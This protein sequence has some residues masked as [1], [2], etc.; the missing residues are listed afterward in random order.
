M[1]LERAA[2]SPGLIAADP[3]VSAW[4]GASAG[5]GK[6]NL[7]ADRVLR[8]L[9][10][11]A[12][13]SA[14]LCLTFTKAAA[15]EMAKRIF[16]RLGRWAVADDKELSQSLRELLGEAPL[17]PEDL[18][19]ARQLFA[20][21][22]DAPGG[23]RIQ[24][25]HAF[26]ESLLK[27]F[28]LE[29]NV[30]PQFAI[31]DERTQAD[32]VLEAQN[33]LFAEA[34]KA[35][36]GALGRAL[37]HLAS[38]T[39]EQ[40]LYE[41]FGEIVKDRKKFS[42]LLDDAKG[43][44]GL[45]VKLRRALGLGRDETEQTALGAFIAEI[46]R[47]KA[48]RAAE[49][50]GHGAKTDLRH[51]ALI[52][53]WLQRPDAAGAYPDTLN[54]LFLTDEGEA[55]KTLVT[56][57]I[58][59]KFPDMADWLKE[60]QARA[61][62]LQDKLKTIRTFAAT[63]AMLRLADFLLAL[64]EDKKRARTLL[65][66]EDLIHTARDLVQTR[67]L[68][69]WVL[70]KLDQGIDH[71]L[72]D[73]AQDTSPAQ[74][75][76]IAA[77]AEEFFAGLGAREIERT[78]FAVGD[79]KQSIFSF[80]GAEPEAFAEMREHFRAKVED[81]ARAFRSVPLARNYRSVPAILAAV[82]RVFALAQ[83]KEG[84]V[85]DGP[86]RHFA[87]REGQG[88]F[89][90]LW[91]LTEPL[92]EQPADPWDAPL[93]YVGPGR[94]EARLARRI[95]ETLK[96]WIGNEVLAAQGRPVKAGDIMILVR[97]RG[98]FFEH[99]VRELKKAGV[100]VAGA[101]R[102]VLA[103]HLAVMDL[104]A[105]GAFA[106][107]PSD[108]L[109]LAI[110]LKSP[111]FGFDDDDLLK[112]CAGRR[113]SLWHALLARQTEHAHWQAAADELGRLLAEADFKPP[114]EFYA[115]LLGARQGRARILARLGPDAADPMDEFLNAA[116]TY[117]SSHAA[118]LQGFLH[119]FALGQSVIKRDLEQAGDQVRVMTVHGAKGLEANIVFL[120]ETTTKPDGRHDPAFFWSEGEGAALPMRNLGQASDV[121]QAGAA[122]ASWRAA[123]EREYRRLLY[124]AMTRAR[125][126]L[127]VCGWRPKRYQ[128]EGTWYGLIKTALEGPDVREVRLAN[129]E[130]GS[131]LE[132]SQ[133]QEPEAREPVRESPARPIPALFGTLPDKEPTP[134]RPLSPS[135]PL[136]LEPPPASPLA[137]PRA[138]A[139]ERGALVHR[140]LEV[141]P[142]I[143]PHRRED[144]ARALIARLAP[145]L[146]VGARTE[147][148]ASALGVLRDPDC[149]GVFA[150]E[151]R[152]EVPILG[153]IGDF[154]ISGRIDR[155]AV[156]GEEVAILDYK[157]NRTPPADQSGVSPVYLRQMAAYR[158]IISR[159]YPAH[160]VRAALLWTSAPKLM[161]LD[162][163]RLD[164]ALRA[165]TETP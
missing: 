138:I 61:L 126:R 42:G 77:L 152:S 133:E 162:D 31:A 69:P 36:D 12:R 60:A 26:C 149:A 46:D 51:S 91:P 101:D 105:V 44:A 29:A 95:A 17:A 88:G 59:K 84:V 3:S 21:T 113:G 41:A 38:T 40:T 47:V 117:Q 153:R 142:K 16:E 121:A 70:Y 33:A 11:G 71:I 163:E 8:L 57:A 80:Q 137:E 128:E 67:E 98:P 27:R 99:M 131:R 55:R 74:W 22:L 93:D 125:D 89:V 54:K 136:D 20:R 6:T 49:I 83:A 87:E 124:V 102:L 63:E 7:L 72:I 2:P 97:Q 156:M 103:E 4:V 134:S 78:V 158:A 104:A 1:S 115:E 58:A 140:L 56:A 82:D 90:E 119:W 159:L 108:D 10:Q 28:P 110:V 79:E 165:L 139:F 52:R 122:R 161:W 50:L 32:L 96:G 107:L 147:I 114:F 65:D 116:L 39:A 76:V 148:A 130:V 53:E 94:P 9:L 75:Q 123:Q 135:R 73:E 66:Y 25:I 127:Y 132:T 86:L 150:A 129:G 24:T 34:A 157:T 81:V 120:A 146:P 118:S 100:P 5:T 19:R 64:Y 35:P 143:A 13:P 85:T 48:Q 43:A 141:L 30:P 68:A 14:V 151:A 37:A 109:T 155:L 112:L 45:G 164:R 18:S 92:D 160:R 145:A 154:A 111:L 62:A 144:A 23:L 106:L 15:S